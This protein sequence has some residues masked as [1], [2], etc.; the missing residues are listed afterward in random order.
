MAEGVEGADADE[1]INFFG[2][3]SDAQE[4]IGQGRERGV[5]AFG[6]DGVAVRV[7]R[8][9]SCKRGTRILLVD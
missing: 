6:E 1:G 3:R 5:G 2:Q 9:F 4:E 8:P 7:V